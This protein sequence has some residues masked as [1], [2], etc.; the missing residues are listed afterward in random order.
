MPAHSAAS[1]HISPHQPLHKLFDV[2]VQRT[3]YL[4][5]GM[6]DRDLTGYL[7]DVLTRFTHVDDIFRI[8]DAN[9]SGWATPAAGS[10]GI[11][12]SGKTT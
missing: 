4:R 6:P 9:G 5:F 11:R 8:R 10:P 2:L 3:F 7:A 12:C 1:H